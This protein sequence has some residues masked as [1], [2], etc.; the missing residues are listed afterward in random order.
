MIEYYSFISVQIMSPFLGF[1][2]DKIQFCEDVRMSLR[3][4]GV[5]CS[6]F[7]FMATK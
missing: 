3:D 1:Q 5:S 7:A 2:S 6:S 4:W